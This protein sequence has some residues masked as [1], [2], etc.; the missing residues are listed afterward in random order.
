[1][2]VTP[3][4]YQADNWLRGCNPAMPAGGRKPVV[5]DA[6]TYPS[7]IAEN[8]RTATGTRIY[9]SDFFGVAPDVLERTAPS[10]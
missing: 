1:M 4:Q 9:F 2:R 3:D 7:A 8:G 5:L 6:E 10:T